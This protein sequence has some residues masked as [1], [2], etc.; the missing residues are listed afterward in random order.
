MNRLYILGAGAGVK[1]LVLTHT[2]AALVAAKEQGIA[3]VAEIYKGKI[4]FAEE[5]LTLELWA[6]QGWKEQ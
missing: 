3:E 5:L 1:T 2:G 4:V 6:A